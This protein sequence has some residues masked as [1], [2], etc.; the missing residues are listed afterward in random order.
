MRIIYIF[1]RR[2]HY[3]YDDKIFP[4]TQF[5][6]QGF[7]V[8]VW[9]LVNWTFNNVD[10]PLNV[11]KTGRGIYIDNSNDFNSN[12]MRVR[13]EKCVFIIFPYHA[14][15]SISAQVRKRIIKENHYFFNMCE[16]IAFTNKEYSDISKNRILFVMYQEIKFLLYCIIRG[17]KITQISYLEHWYPLIYK[18]TKNFLTVNECMRS[19]PNKFEILSKRNLV[20]NSSDYSTYLENK[21]VQF[22]EN[23]KNKII[24]VDQYLTGHSDFKKLGMKEP[25]P[26]EVLY[27]KECNNFFRILEEKYGAEVVIAAHP[28]AE[29]RG[30]E[31]SGRRIIYGQ[32]LNLIKHGKLI[33]L[34]DS[35]AYGITCYQKKDFIIFAS[36]QLVNGIL[37]EEIVNLSKFFKSEICIM[38]D[39]KAGNDIKQYINRYNENYDRFVKTYVL[40]PNGIDDKKI[41]D[42]IIENVNEVISKKDIK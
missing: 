5:E 38:S 30:D 42:V 16:S 6:Q 41:S 2:H 20:I 28:K 39:V 10:V 15:T 13:G 26:N 9:S 40:S 14:Y 21:N 1:E 22:E 35:T 31:F 36:C 19:F 3:N 7:E 17:K 4:I 24:F 11:D 27:F 12:M 25:I 34:T 33:L 23:L 18:S 29:Y 37:W 8:E 32:T